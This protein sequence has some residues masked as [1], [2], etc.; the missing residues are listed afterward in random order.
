M[1]YLEFGILKNK[2]KISYQ[3]VKNHNLY[4]WF[5]LPRY[6]FDLV[7]I[8][9]YKK[10]INLSKKINHSKD[11][12]FNFISLILCKV[13]LENQYNCKF[14]E[15]GFTLLEKVTFF[16]Y[17]KKIL[18]LKI[19][20]NKI[21]FCGNEISKNFIF[22]ANNFYTKVKKKLFV[23]FNK[24]YVKN[25]IFYSKGISL[26]YEKQNLNILKEVLSKCY[27]GSFDFSVNMKRKSILQLET[28]YK[29]H[30]PYLHDF[31]KILGVINKTNQKTI[32]FK[33]I[34]RQGDYLY[35]EVLFG[36]KK[37]ITSF[38]K[39]MKILKKKLNDQERKILDLDVNYI[40][41]KNANFLK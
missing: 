34:S 14:Y 27:A 7:H 29:M 28:G 18:K 15:H 36:K 12:K 41:L 22:F 3:I 39:N 9:S 25:S 5:M 30:Y 21:I 24:Q 8:S 20:L 37:I 35:F 38:F 4:D 23:K 19:K 6:F 33:N 31:I 17:L 26:L 32:Y 1:N 40:N 2:K 10:L 11:L 13:T 16:E